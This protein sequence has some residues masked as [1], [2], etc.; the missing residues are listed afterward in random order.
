MLKDITLG[1]YFPGKSAIHR[2][3]P[4]AKL[5]MLVVYIVGLF[6]AASWIS[7]GLML[8]FLAVV[9]AISRIPLKSILRGMKPLVV[10]LLFT[11]VLTL[12][13][14]SPAGLVFFS[15]TTLLSGGGVLVFL[16]A[17]LRAERTPALAEAWLCC[18]QL[19]LIGALGTVLTSLITLLSTSLE[20]GLYIGAALVFASLFL[21][22]GGLICFLRR[23][24]VPRCHCGG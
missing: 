23:Y 20:V 6:A 24:L 5:I 1:Q 14:T 3:D 22:L 17:A 10:I 9:I 15:L 12:V 11:G 7:Y 18:G 4:R 13:P 16:L 8:V 2:M 21:F 19:S